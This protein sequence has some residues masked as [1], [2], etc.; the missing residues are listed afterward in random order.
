[1]YRRKNLK[2]SLYVGIAKSNV[3]DLISVRL[4]FT[5]GFHSLSS[6]GT[7]EVPIY[8]IQENIETRLP[9]EI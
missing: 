8:T 6:N 1:M 9:Q 2:I 5:A 4:I 7:F 3:C